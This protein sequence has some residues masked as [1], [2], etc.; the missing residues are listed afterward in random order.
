MKQQAIIGVDIG[1]TSTKAVAF[2][3]AGKPLFQYAVEYPILSTDP[4][5]AEQDPDQ[6]FEAVLKALKTV[7]TLV[8]EG[9]YSLK[10]VS[11][12]S[13]MHS[14]IAMDGE[15]SRLTNCIIWADTRSKA[16]ANALRGTPKGLDI[17]LQTGT[18]I[19]PMSPLVK[20]AWLREKHPATFEKTAKFIGIKEYVFFKLFGE[21]KVDYSIASATG[22]FNIFTLDWY[23]EALEVAGVTADVLPEPVPPTYSFRSLKPAYAL[24]LSIPASVPFV[25]GASDGCLANLGSNAVQAGHG[26]VTIGTSGAIRVTSDKPATDQLERIFS[27]IL[28]P[29]HYVLG[30]AV[31]N[32]G[33]ILRW[34]RDNF[35]ALE[36]AEARRNEIDPYDL[37]AE[38]AAA[39]P[40]GS[41]GLLC[42]P[43]LLGE[44]SPIWDASARGCFIGAHYNHT[45]EH[46]LRAMMEGVI[47]G[48]YS[49]GKALEQTVGPI[50]AIYA[51][52]GFSKS[53]MWVQM[54]ADVFNKKVMLTETPEGSAFGAAVLGM[55]A[56]GM[57]ENLEEAEQMITVTQTFVPDQ[58]VHQQY[59]HNYTL[60]EELYPKLKDTF[61]KFT[62]W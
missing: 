33:V 58:A 17:Y 4:E 48:V 21:Y 41:D 25:I 12:S 7:S 53:A 22:L 52:G 23:P 11:F 61:Q 39:I 49:V 27:Y 34:F 43:Y 55:Y 10:G 44:R 6:V 31:N 47:F 28:T 1:T 13:A 50:D 18:P 20:L 14:L 36:A 51:N 19:H 38:K 3:V 46:F 60:F 32:G 29:E 45:R 40:P 30:G 57:I 9:E 16:Q 5:M 15:G 56:L 35:Y 24:K 37:M 54:L 26:V 8:V 59:M 62:E 2:G 42:L